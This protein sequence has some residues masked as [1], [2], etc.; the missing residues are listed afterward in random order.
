MLIPKNDF[1]FI[2]YQFFELIQ[3]RH[4]VIA[5]SDIHLHL[6]T[7]RQ[8]LI[9]KAIYITFKVCI[10]SVH[11]FP[12]NRTHDLD[13]ASDMPYC[14]SDRNFWRHKIER[15]KQNFPDFFQFCWHYSVVIRCWEKVL[16]FIS[17]SDP[18]LFTY[19]ILT[20]AFFPTTFS[21][22]IIAGPN[23]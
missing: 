7:F 12:G 2:R 20:N 19:N 17:F 16:D 10:L 4:F 1:F 13:I 9:S 23:S 15:K 14:W 21:K 5:S 8:T 18:V 3:L 6:C 11:A 22:W